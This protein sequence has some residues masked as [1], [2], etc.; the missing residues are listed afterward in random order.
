MAKMD[1]NPFVK[2]VGEESTMKTRFEE[3]LKLFAGCRH[4]LIITYAPSSS[5]E[6]IWACNDCN[7]RFYPACSTCV[8]V[9][10]RGEVHVD[11]T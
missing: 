4:D 6:R 7:K 8:D 3:R 5:D 9:G 2:V 1:G 10:H 11:G